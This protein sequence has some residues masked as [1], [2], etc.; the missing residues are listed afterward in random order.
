[1]KHLNIDIWDGFSYHSK[2]NGFRPNL[3]TYILDN[4][5]LKR[6][7]VL[8]CPGGGYSRVSERE[9]EP[10]AIKFNEA[11]FNA[12]VLNYSV[13]SDMHPTP[14]YDVSR[15][16]C[17]I[18]ENEDKWN[19]NSDQIA[20]CGFS[21]GGHLAASLGVFWNEDFIFLKEGIKRGLT[22]PNLLI[23]AYP[24]ISSE[25][26]YIHEGSFENLLGK[27]KS[28][29]ND[30]SLEKK[31]NKNTP[32]TFLWHTLEDSSVKVENSILFA[33]SLRKYDIPFEL[34]IFP[35]GKHG[36]S[37]ATKETKRDDIEEDSHVATWMN[38][39]I[40]WININFK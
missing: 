37:L 29:Y 5:G 34:H 2:N 12:F 30:L 28:F 35:Y 3:V 23:L 24:V 27:D 10:V 13:Y 38:L 6:P 11:G 18:R 14:I 32:A 15:A 19:I 1:L 26:E 33:K 22:K 17:I 9:S 21:A 20:V 16:I 40:E 39:C 4:N 36:M 7:S 8:I 31:V 25:K